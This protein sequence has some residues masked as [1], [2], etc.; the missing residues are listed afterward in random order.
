MKSY[1]RLLPV[2]AITA[3]PCLA[4]A[5]P[6][7]LPIPP[8]TTTE[9]PPGVSV[10]ET[11]SGPVYVDAQG[12]TL[13]GL[14]MRTVK[15]W[16]PDPAMYCKQGCDDWEPLLAPAGAKP[17]I[18]YPQGF[19]S[20]RREAQ[21]EL[22]EK[23]FH[24]NPQEAPDWTIIEGPDGPQWV[25]KGWHVVYARKGDGPGSTEFDGADKFT[26]NTLKFV[27]PVP[28]VVAP[29]NV[30]TIFTDG[31]YALADSEGRLL[32]TGECD[33]AVKDCS[34]WTPLAAGLASRGIGQWGVNR[35]GDTP[36]WT[37]R[38]RPV[39]VSELDEL[40]SVPEG[41]SVLRP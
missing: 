40:G 34:D 20:Q 31:A 14:D 37:Y 29:E 23:G 1:R 30:A 26:W 10:A 16:S 13:Y 8:A 35:A 28:E 22:R 41:G 3:I 27:P 4:W 33:R 21:E 12:R 38:G 39:F 18:L 25:Y 17:N 19:G 9:Y 15:R 7:D 11:E 32:Y 2:V 6:S 24:A 36:Q 5:Q